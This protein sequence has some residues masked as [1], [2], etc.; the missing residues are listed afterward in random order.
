MCLKM[1][2]CHGKIMNKIEDTLS[3]RILGQKTWKLMAIDDDSHKLFDH[4]P[5]AGTIKLFTAV[6][7]AVS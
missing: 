7:V 3:F 4:F 6:I 2:D 1:T 5:G